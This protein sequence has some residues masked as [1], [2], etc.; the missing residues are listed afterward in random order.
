MSLFFDNV[1]YAG[2]S[3][4]GGSLNGVQFGLYISNQRKLT[5]TYGEVLG[6]APEELVNGDYSFD[7]VKD[8][9]EI[10]LRIEF[11]AVDYSYVKS[12]IYKS[13][14]TKPKLSSANNT[15]KDILIGIAGIKNGNPYV[16]G[17]YLITDPYIN[18]TI[19]ME[20]THYSDSGK[21]QN[22]LYADGD[23]LIITDDTAAGSYL[24][25]QTACIVYS[26]E[27]NINDANSGDQF[28]MSLDNEGGVATLTAHTGT[29]SNNNFSGSQNFGLVA[30][31]TNGETTLS[32]YTSISKSGQA[33]QE[34]TLYVTDQGTAEMHLNCPSSSVSSSGSSLKM[35]C[36]ASPAPYDFVQ[37]DLNSNNNDSAKVGVTG[38]TKSKKIDFYSEED[39]I[40]GLEI[41]N[42]NKAGDRAN[43]IEMQ[44]NDDAQ[45]SVRGRS[46]L[47]ISSGSKNGVS[48]DGPIIS[49][50]TDSSNTDS[51]NKYYDEAAIVIDSKTGNSTIQTR[52]STSQ[53]NTY[54]NQNYVLLDNNTVDKNGNK[55]NASI[56][57]DAVS[58]TG[59][60]YMFGNAGGW[61][62]NLGTSENSGSLYLRRKDDL[63]SKISSYI[64]NQQASLELSGKTEGGNLADYQFIKMYCD[65]KSDYAQLQIGNG[66]NANNYVLLK[67][68]STGASVCGQHDFYPDGPVFQL[69]ADEQTSKASG[70]YSRALLYLKDGGDS[71]QNS[72]A[73]YSSGGINISK[74]SGSTYR[75]FSY[76]SGEDASAVNDGILSLSSGS[77]SSTLSGSGTLYLQDSN[78]N[79]ITL[80][81]LAM[82]FYVPAAST[83]YTGYTS[84]NK[85]GT[86]IDNNGVIIQ[87]STGTLV[88]TAQG[89]KYSTPSGVKTSTG[90][91][92]FDASGIKTIIG[93]YGLELSGTLFQYT[94]KETGLRCS[95]AFK[96]GYLETSVFDAR[97]LIM[98]DPDNGI[99]PKIAMKVDGG[100]GKLD[101]G[102]NGSAYISNINSGTQAGALTTA[103]SR[104][105]YIKIWDPLLCYQDILFGYYSN[106]RTKTDMTTKYMRLNLYDHNFGVFGDNQNYSLHSATGLYIIQKNANSYRYDAYGVSYGDGTTASL[107]SVDNLSFDGP[108]STVQTRYLKVP[109]NNQGWKIQALNDFQID[110]ALFV[111]TIKSPPNK[112]KLYV[113][114]K[115]VLYNGIATSDNADK[116]YTKQSIS[117]CVNG[118]IK[119]M[120][121]LGYLA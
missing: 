37:V 116:T 74:G 96:N 23:G 90:S 60:S 48:T 57:L 22:I 17:Q 107:L 93:P 10:L 76:D 51:N 30:D 11:N 104:D 62:Y 18:N 66:W 46:G 120:Y 64:A 31:D 34:A 88:I 21:P 40:A 19:Y 79:S 9:E 67:K 2:G 117:V 13:S 52:C 112:D 14:D 118:E 26:N 29:Q 50:Y 1:T 47:N 61:E 97:G 103:S 70:K 75:A 84:L 82:Q 108:N 78:K 38:A 32:L 72:N 35:H 114:P 5:V 3:S 55:F 91:L 4:S 100:N 27:V 6:N 58:A 83:G 115:I 20:G 101:L 119:T 42:I 28:S 7:S 94:L 45:Y 56:Q 65:S 121:V 113:G 44:V 105:G 49:L 15:F 110:G 16:D 109:T 41:Y 111:E 54:C 106:N 73:T 89:F 8:G 39:N 98:N 95:K 87:D 71:V 86:Y 99:D 53:C 68:D 80:T 69:I 59:T 81:P 25:S 43:A 102:P 24:S 85:N 33:N 12:N 77:V 63:G 92:E 36:S